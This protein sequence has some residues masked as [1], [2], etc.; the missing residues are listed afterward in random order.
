MDGVFVPCL[1]SKHTVMVNT[2]TYWPVAL[3]LIP[4]LHVDDYIVDTLKRLTI[5]IVLYVRNLKPHI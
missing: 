2:L 4:I 5:N 1:E 3:L